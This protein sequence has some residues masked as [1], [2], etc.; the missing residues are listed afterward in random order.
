MVTHTHSTS[1]QSEHPNLT[2]PTTFDLKF[3]EKIE[4]INSKQRGRPKIHVLPIILSMSASQN[5]VEKRK[6]EKNKS[7]SGKDHSWV[8]L[9]LTPQSAKK[10]LSTIE[11]KQNL[12]NACFYNK[13]AEGRKRLQNI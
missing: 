5:K 13:H 11:N 6:R 3:K 7:K 2:A 10:K 8:E 1:F 4:E 12:I 9:L